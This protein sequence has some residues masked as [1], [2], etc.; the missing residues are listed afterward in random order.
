MQL[1]NLI[2]Y[3]DTDMPR[4]IYLNSAYRNAQIKR[5]DKKTLSKL[6]NEIDTIYDKS[7]LQH[8]EN[9]FSIVGCL[10]DQ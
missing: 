4:A 6:W 8:N 5:W 10:E 9:Q 2:D 1:E 7:F 3:I